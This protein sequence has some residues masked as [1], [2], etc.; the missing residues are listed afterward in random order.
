MYDNRRR[1]FF[2][3]GCPPGVLGMRLVPVNTFLAACRCA[4]TTPGQDCAPVRVE[5]GE[6][7]HDGQE[8]RGHSR[9]GFCAA[10]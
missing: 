5:E 6:R 7:T 8:A 2:E 1:D 4:M 10:N 3:L 9:T